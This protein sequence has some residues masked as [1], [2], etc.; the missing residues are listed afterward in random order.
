[1]AEQHGI[2]V[3]PHVLQAAL[4]IPVIHI[5]AT[6]NQGVRE[7]VDAAC[8]LQ[9]LRAAW[10]PNRPTIRPEHEPILAAVRALIAGHTPPALS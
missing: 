4:G 5:V 7:L 10:A 6:Q 3:E 8:E 9:Q 1:M 2:H